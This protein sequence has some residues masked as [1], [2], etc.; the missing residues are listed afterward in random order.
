VY[1]F[2]TANNGHEYKGTFDSARK[3][4]VCGTKSFL[5]M[6]GDDKDPFRTLTLLKK[7]LF[8]EASISSTS[9][10]NHPVLLIGTVPPAALRLLSH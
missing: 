5:T 6:N 1:T 8:K 4:F 9:L 10:L 2:V 7:D 3:D